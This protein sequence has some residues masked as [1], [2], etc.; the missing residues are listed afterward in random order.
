MRTRTAGCTI[1]HRRHAGAARSLIDLRSM[2]GPEDCRPGRPGAEPPRICERRSRDS[3]AVHRWSLRPTANAG[4]TP[5]R[6]PGR[7]GKHRRRHR[8]HRW[9]KPPQ[10]DGGASSAC[11]RC[12]ATADP[13][14]RLHPDKP[15]RRAPGRPVLRHGCGESCLF[16]AS[17]VVGSRGSTTDRGLDIHMRHANPLLD[18]RDDLLRS[19]TRLPM[20]RPS[21]PA[22]P[23]HRGQEISCS[24][25]SSWHRRRAD[26]S[27]EGAVGHHSASKRA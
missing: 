23:C 20:P 24:P 6:D 2:A 15:M 27:D 16:A 25:G 22:S 26:S 8:S 9:A 13:P 21:G 14:R 4:G 7:N 5:T 1:R 12:N 10:Q 18:V 19:A 17:P 3:R 11:T